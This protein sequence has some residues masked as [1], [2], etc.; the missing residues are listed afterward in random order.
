MG[1]T[2][3]SCPTSKRAW[4]TS[5]GMSP[6]S[7]V[8]NPDARL[9]MHVTRVHDVTTLRLSAD[10]TAV[11]GYGSLISR[12]SIARTLGHPYDGFF[13]PCHIA[14]WRRTWDIGMPNRAYYSDSGAERTYPEKILYLNVR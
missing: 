13:S 6:P 4:S 2:S 5:C 7:P 11:V 10:Q 9:S 12:P 8:P 1:S 14:G 3:G